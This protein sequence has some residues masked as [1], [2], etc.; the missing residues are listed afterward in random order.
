MVVSKIGLYGIYKYIAPIVVYI[1]T[2][3]FL[4]I[5]GRAKKLLNV[6]DS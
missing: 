5:V 6:G 2:I 1:S 3:A 4:V